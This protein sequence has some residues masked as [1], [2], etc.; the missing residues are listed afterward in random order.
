L[1]NFVNIASE[2]PEL[3]PTL[4]RK[5]VARKCKLR[6]QTSPFYKKGWFKSRILPV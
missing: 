2:A 5:W 6:Q 3:T 1:Q 4:I